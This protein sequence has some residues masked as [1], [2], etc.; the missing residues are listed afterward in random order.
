MATARRTYK[1][2]LD[3]E[4]SSSLKRAQEHKREIEAIEKA[5]KL[6]QE[7]MHDAV[8]QHLHYSRH[9]TLA[10]IH[11]ASLKSDPEAYNST[12]SIEHQS[13]CTADTVLCKK[14]RNR[15]HQ[16][17]NKREGMSTS[18]T[19]HLLPVMRDLFS[20]KKRNLVWYHTPSHTLSYTVRRIFCHYHCK[21]LSIT[22]S[23]ASDVFI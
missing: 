15:L 17:E 8:M 14:N 22:S 1:Q 3:E 5:G 16:V 21:A 10:R 12:H 11:M 7:E 23:L 20:P 13:K 4:N 9:L 19:C 2:L 6:E 18:L